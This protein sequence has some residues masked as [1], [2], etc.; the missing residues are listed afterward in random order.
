MF[1]SG[2]DSSLARLFLGLIAE[3]SDAAAAEACSAASSKDSSVLGG[4]AG[5]L[6][7]LVLVAFLAVGLTGDQDGV[8]RTRRA[9]RGSAAVACTGAA[10]AATSGD[11][12]TPPPILTTLL[13]G[14]LSG[15]RPAFTLSRST[16]RR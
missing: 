10:A 11:A 16:I 8:S 7:W 15:S 6:G 9:P 14:M 3:R 12:A 2:C 4:H 1:M 13:A 5:E